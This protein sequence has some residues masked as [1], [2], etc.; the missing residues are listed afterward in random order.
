M[1]ALIAAFL[2][3]QA[4]DQ[5]PELQATEKDVAWEI[6]TIDTYGAYS[7]TCTSLC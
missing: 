4:A 7:H 1:P 3:W 5:P 6:L 2:T